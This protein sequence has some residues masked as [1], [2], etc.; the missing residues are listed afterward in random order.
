[1]RAFYHGL[2]QLETGM[3]GKRSAQARVIMPHD[4]IQSL[5]DREQR[6]LIALASE[7]SSSFI[8]PL[9]PPFCPVLEG[10]P[11]GDAVI[12]TLICVGQWL[13]RPVSGLRP[14]TSVPFCGYEGLPPVAGFIMGTFSEGN[15]LIE[16]YRKVAAGSPA[17][18]ELRDEG[19]PL[20]VWRIATLSVECE[21]AN[22][23]ASSQYT[24][25]PG[26]WERAQG[27]KAH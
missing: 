8:R 18:R 1:M 4:S 2:N 22:A 14:A 27:Q 25:T 17:L 12:G 23:Y 9:L 21:L 20:T 16:A 10:G 3:T 13:I 26:P 24:F 19:I 11:S 15:R 7:G 6:A 5:L